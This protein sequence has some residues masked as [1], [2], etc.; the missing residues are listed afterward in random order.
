MSHDQSH[1]N[2]TLWLVGTL[3]AF[4][5][6]YQVALLPLYFRIQQDLNLSS[7]EQ[8]TLLVTILGV[9]YFLPSYPLGVMADRFS[10]K[11]VLGIGLGVNSLGFMAL[12]LAPSYGWAL[13]GAAV[14][15][16]G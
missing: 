4:T 14:A 9:A 11:K 16:F 12:G 13:A 2:R 1:K 10:R 8:A 7:V 15:G 6:L 5:H 3:H